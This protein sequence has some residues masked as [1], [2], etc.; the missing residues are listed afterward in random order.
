MSDG[1]L[2]LISGEARLL[3]GWGEMLERDDEPILL[4]VDVLLAPL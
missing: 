2:R 3:V 4:L 1:F